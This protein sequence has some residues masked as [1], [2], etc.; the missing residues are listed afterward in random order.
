MYKEL[1]KEPCLV[2]ALAQEQQLQQRIDDVLTKRE[3]VD[4]Y[5]LV[6]KHMMNRCKLTVIS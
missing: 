1:I 2:N 6:L 3:E 5:T 4:M